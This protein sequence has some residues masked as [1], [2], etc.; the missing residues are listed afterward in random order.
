MSFPII[1]QLRVEGAA[2]AR[3]QFE[4]LS[5]AFKKG[6]VSA[7][8]VNRALVKMDRANAQVATST[9]RAVNAWRAAHPQLATLERGLSRIGS[10]ANYVRGIFDSW[11]ILQIALSGSS[12]ELSA[13]LS[14]VEKAQ[15]DYNIAVATFS[16]DSPQAIEALN[17]L[18]DANRKLEDAQK[19]QSDQTVQ[20]GFQLAT[21][22]LMIGGAIAQTAVAVGAWMSLHGT[23]LTLTSVLG[24]LAVGLGVG[25][26][27]A[28]V[29]AGININRFKTDTNTWREAIELAR[30]DVQKLPPVIRELADVATMAAGGWIRFGEDLAFTVTDI[31]AKLRAWSRGVYEQ[32][33]GGFQDTWTRLSEGWNSFRGTLEGIWASLTGGGWVETA[34]ST[35][36]GGWRFITNIIEGIWNNLLT[37]AGNI[38][39]GIVTAI[40]KGVDDAVKRVTGF[41]D[42]VKKAFGDLWNRLVGGSIVPE[43]MSDINTAI[44]N[45]LDTSESKFENWRHNIVS[46]MKETQKEVVAIAEGT[47]AALTP[48]EAYERAIGGGLPPTATKGAV[49]TT[50]EVSPGRYDIRGVSWPMVNTGGDT[51]R[52]PTYEEQ[53]KYLEVGH[54]A[55]G[56][57]VTE[58][59]LALLGEK[60]PEEVRPLGRPGL[61]GGLGNVYVTVN[62]QGFVGSEE[63][64]VSLVSQGIR[65]NV[66]RLFR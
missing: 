39:N 45:G 64:L 38:W 12:G 46:T 50:V 10:L 25:L 3:T 58:P 57:L 44:A 47:W 14:D 41:V 27:A 20:A 8:D 61:T 17:K 43:M 66:G 48:T 60:G 29:A 62:I 49:G 63:D 42:E 13:A 11:N 34:R 37:I 9:N 40:S 19:K 21:Y 31:D 65:R 35:I 22:S 33:R 6:E 59:T 53:V 30:E 2:Q 18:T 23:T 54:Y 56:G 16:E 36:E 7:E 32:V 28:V 5:T 24:G 55:R 15:R 51:W 52:G 4:N 1:Y 26:I